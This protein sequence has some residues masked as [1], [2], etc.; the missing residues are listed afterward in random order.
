MIVSFHP[1]F[2]AD[3]NIICAGREANREDLLAI[4]AAEAVILPQGCRQT[5]YEMAR[6]YCEHI[7]PNYDVRFRYPGKIGQI[8]LFR[9]TNTYHPKTKI[10]QTADSYRQQYSRVSKQP[11]FK[12]P[13]VFKLDWGGEGDTV[14]LIHSLKTLQDI[15]QQTEI[16]EHSG[17]TGFLFQEYIPNR[18]RTLRVVIIGRQ[19]ISYWR[20]QEAKSG[21]LA[22][23]SRGA[24]I[25]SDS[26][27][28]LQA[29]AVI[30]IE[31]FCKKTEINLAGFDIIYSSEKKRKTPLLLEINYFFGRRGL[32]GSDAYYRILQKKIRHW[33]K[34]LGLE[35]DTKEKNSTVRI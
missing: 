15:L 3:T 1:L 27:P 28:D 23:L 30:S 11:P 7:F 2:E 9:E 10:F 20:I 24:I 19:L 13:F 17:Q 18:N 33:L 4:K 29:K 34:R 26:E 22:N 32:G 31:N 8:Q 25:D 16:F 21:F 6:N 14:Y 35:Y 5:L 12:L